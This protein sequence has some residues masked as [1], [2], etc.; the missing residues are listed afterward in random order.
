MATTGVAGE[1]CPP[2]S[3]EGRLTPQLD[4]L[5]YDELVGNGEGE[6][7]NQVGASQVVH[8]VTVWWLLPWYF[9]NQSKE[10]VGVDEYEVKVHA[11]ED[12]E[13]GEVTSDEE[14]EIK[15]QSAWDTSWRKI[16]VYVWAVG[17]KLW[18]CI[19]VYSSMKW[20]VA[21]LIW[22]WFT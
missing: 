2:P 22:H 1:T 8:H 7:P 19:T 12:I 13:E 10:G 6:G 9:S 16:S 4:E 17:L 11:L 14:G 20:F 5:D 18:S 21:K 15:G 3:S